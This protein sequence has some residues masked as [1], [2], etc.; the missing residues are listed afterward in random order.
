MSEDVFPFPGMRMNLYPALESP[1]ADNLA[2]FDK[3][4]RGYK[5]LRG[6]VAV[7]GAAL[8]K[9]ADPARRLCALTDPIGNTFL[10]E[11]KFLFVAHRP[12]IKKSHPL[13]EP[14]PR[15]AALVRHD[16][17]IKRPLFCTTSC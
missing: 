9:L 4:R 8:Q 1:H 7:Q 14:P 5:L 2:K 15:G 17:R 16:D 11:A 13:N 12:G 3:V 10:I 6:G